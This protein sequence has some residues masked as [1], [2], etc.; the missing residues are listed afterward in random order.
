VDADVSIDGITDHDI[1]PGMSFTLYDYTANSPIT[2]DA[3]YRKLGTQY[4]VKGTAGTG[5]VYLVVQYIV[6]L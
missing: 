4:Y 5:S 3:I 1:V 2:D 6:N